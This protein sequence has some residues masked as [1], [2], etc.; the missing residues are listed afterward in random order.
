MALEYRQLGNSGLEVTVLALGTMTFGNQADRETSFRVLDLALDHGV[1]FIDTAD[2]YP[3]GGGL[4]LAGRTEE[5][6]GEWLT[7]HRGQVVIATK[8]FGAMGSEPH[9]KG[10]SRKHILDAVEASLVRLRTDYIDLYQAHQFDPLTPMEETLRAFDSLVQS[11]KVRYIGVS[12]WRAWQVAKALGIAER[13]HLAPVVSVQPRY[14]LLFRMIEDELLPFARGEGIGVI[15]YNPLAGGMLTGRYRPGQSVEMGTRFALAGAGDL[16]RE[17][18][19]QEATFLAIESYR[20]WCGE[21]G[22]DMIKTAVN[23]VI[24]QPGITSAILGASRPEQLE[25]S[26]AAAEDPPLVTEELQWLDELWFRLPRR[27]EAR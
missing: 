8:C 5:I 2:V 19:W 13:L 17:R 9:E 4:T 15:S 22:R 24:S 18:Y 16:Y 7:D 27:R 23:W 1:R 3:L 20:K 10:L 26:L 25:A 6:V 12:N 11:G 21:H 14:N